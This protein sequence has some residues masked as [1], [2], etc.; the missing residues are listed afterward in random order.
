MKVKE[1]K[2]E[3][4]KVIL[5]AKESYYLWLGGK[6]SDPNNGIK[7][8]WSILNGLMN[9]KNIS[10][11]PPILENGMVITNVANKANILHNYFAQQ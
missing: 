3:I 1:V 6:L 9:K 11:I 7:A 2:G 4:S 8:Y 5:E 10:G